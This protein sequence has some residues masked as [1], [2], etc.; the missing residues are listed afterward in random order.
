MNSV[1]ARLPRHLSKGALKEDFLDIS[2]TRYFGVPKFKNTSA[3]RVIFFL[4]MLKIQSKL[5]KCK[6]KKK[7]KKIIFVC[8]IIASENVAINYL[9]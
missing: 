5:R 6:K 8:E 1:S 4:K 9:C 7:I 3:R 2:L